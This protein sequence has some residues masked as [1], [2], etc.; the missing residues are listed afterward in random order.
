M[1]YKCVLTRKFWP[2]DI[3]YLRERVPREIEFIWPD[4]WSD[5]DLTIFAADADVFLGSLPERALFDRAPKLKFVQIPWNGLDSMDLTPYKDLA[6][7]ICNSHGNAESVAELALSLLLSILKLIPQHDRDMRRGNWR[8]PGAGDCQFPVMLRGR[9]V[10]LLGY[11][12]IAKCLCD[13][14]NPFHV[15]IQALANTTRIED[16]LSISSINELDAICH[17]ADI[18]VNTLPLTRETNNLIGRHQ[19]DQMTDQTFIINVSRAQ[20]IDEKELYKAL[21]EKRIAGAAL[22][23]WYADPPRG[24]MSSPCGHYSFEEFD[25]VVLS[26]HRG[27]MIRGELP[28]M[29]DVVTNLNRLVAGQPLINIINLEKGY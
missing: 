2:T 21:S 22:D 9:K 3:E 18:L 19:F 28:H 26:P 14:L 23:V 15:E 5:D 25:N 4:P 7:P 17:W 6:V 20:V 12:H 1:K 8:R 10:G 16:G 27:G 11:G 29:K 13:L 24:A